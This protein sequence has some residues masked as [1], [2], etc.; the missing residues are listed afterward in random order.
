MNIQKRAQRFAKEVTEHLN[1]NEIQ[2][3]VERL[4]DAGY[5]WGVSE[6]LG[7]IENLLIKAEHLDPSVENTNVCKSIRGFIR[8]VVA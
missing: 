2:L 8:S 6:I 3:P 7:E 4:L 1:E 5:Y